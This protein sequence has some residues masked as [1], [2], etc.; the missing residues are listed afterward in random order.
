MVVLSIPKE[1]EQN[2]NK[3]THSR[4]FKHGLRQVD[5]GAAPAIRRGNV[6]LRQGIARET[7]AKYT[8][9]PNAVP[10]RCLQLEQWQIALSSGSPFTSIAQAP[11]QQRAMRVV[12]TQPPV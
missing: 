3:Q 4:D 7:S 8:D 5:P 11:Q 1:K 10:V 2:K 6:G 12:I 9:Q